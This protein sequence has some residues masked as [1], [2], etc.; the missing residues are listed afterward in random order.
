MKR[1]YLALLTLSYMIVTSVAPI[2]GASMEIK[3][4]VAAQTETTIT[5][6]MPITK[7]IPVTQDVPLGT[8]ISTIIFDDSLMIDNSITEEQWRIQHNGWITD[9]NVPVMSEPSVESEMI[10]KKMFNDHISFT[11]YNEKWCCVQIYHPNVNEIGIQIGMKKIEG[12]IDMNYV[13]ET[14]NACKEY[15]IPN[16]EGFKSFMS[17]KTITDK[18]SRQYELQKEYAYTGDYG[19]R[20]VNG[21]FCVAI[22]TAFDVKTG[23]Y[24]DL[25]LENGT[26]I[27]CIVGDI[28][29]EN[30]TL[31][32]NITTAKN[33]CVSEFIVDIRKLKRNIKTH[34][35]VS[36]AESSWNSPVVKIYVYNKN[37]LD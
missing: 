18:S 2:V 15:H 3:T 28:K 23:T 12:Y 36:Y 31:S 33:G 4:D 10:D 25:I 7:E 32:D 26:V 21:R 27:P 9:D 29:A 6:E 5:K 34:G 30:H 20:K 1:R 8:G 22:G 37:V 13:S 19:V 11:Y 14:S 17:Y 16:S 35:D 24:F